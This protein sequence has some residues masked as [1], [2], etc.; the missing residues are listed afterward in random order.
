MEKFLENEVDY[1]GNVGNAFFEYAEKICNE[2]DKILKQDEKD[3]RKKVYRNM[4]NLLTNVEVTNFYVLSVSSVLS[5]DT[6]TL[7][8]LGDNILRYRDLHNRIS[9]LLSKVVR[10]GNIKF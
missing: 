6:T 10:R 5:D 9:E 8:P 7:K 4:Y 1:I 3:V 2:C